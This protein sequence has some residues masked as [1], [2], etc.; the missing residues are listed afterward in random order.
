M[1]PTLAFDFITQYLDCE[2]VWSSDFYLCH[3]LVALSHLLH[4]F[5]L[6]PLDH[7]GLVHPSHVPVLLLAGHGQH[8][9]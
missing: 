7:E 1:S 2:N 8:L 4:V 3:L 6:Q 9:C 5:L